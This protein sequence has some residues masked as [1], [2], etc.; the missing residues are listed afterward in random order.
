M[1]GECLVVRGVALQWWQWRPVTW[2]PASSHGSK[3]VVLYPLS[4]RWAARSSGLIEVPVIHG[5]A[6]VV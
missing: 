4:T 1:N 5:R 6:A 2:S 3:S